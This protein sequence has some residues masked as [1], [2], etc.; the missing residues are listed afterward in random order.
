MSEY[1]EVIHNIETGEIT[2]R[3]FTKD[4]VSEIKAAEAKVKAE[5]EE[6]AA[7][8][9]ERAATKTAILDR[10]GLT[11]DEAKLLLG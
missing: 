3:P 1:K 9:A 6:L 5:L 10:L 8:E 7:T 4:E 2:E 11:E